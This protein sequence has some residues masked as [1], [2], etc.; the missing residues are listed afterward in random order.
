MGRHAIAIAVLLAFTALIDCSVLAEEEIETT[1]TFKLNEN[2][3]LKYKG[4]TRNE[5]NWMGNSIT[6]I[7]SI[8]TSISPIAALEDGNFRVEIHFDKYSEKML[9]GTDLEE[10]ESRIKAEGATVKLIVSPR[11]EV[12][13]VM[14]VI[15]GIGKGEA[16]EDFIEK[17][18]FELPEGPVKKGSSWI[19][20]IN[21]PGKNEGDEPEL[22]GKIEFKL[23]KFDKK[24]GIDVARISSKGE[25]HLNSDTPQGVVIGSVKVE[26]DFY[27][28]IDGGYVVEK[29]SSSEMKGEMVSVDDKTGKETSMD[30]SR[31]A[32]EEFK[33]QD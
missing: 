31:F 4:S 3:V 7:Q 23:E 18:F 17:W 6:N 29:K 14:G 15:P 21:R 20:D 10:R 8:E 26:G 25:L 33:L 1:L 24:K 30:V 32:F 5:T 27:I 22:S 28:A 13:E 19:K 16:L 2:Q 12:I 9:M 11:A